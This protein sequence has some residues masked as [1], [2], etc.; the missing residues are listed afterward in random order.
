M[1]RRATVYLREENGGTAP[2]VKARKTRKSKPK[3]KPKT[4]PKAA[5]PRSRRPEKR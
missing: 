1:G 2:L 4:K 5:S 3:A